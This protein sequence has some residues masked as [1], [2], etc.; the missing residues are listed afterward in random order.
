MINNSTD[1]NNKIHEIY[2]LKDTFWFGNKS[3]GIELEI[4]MIP[5]LH[6]LYLDA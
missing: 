1:F 6:S 4:M 2:A 5:T 3:G